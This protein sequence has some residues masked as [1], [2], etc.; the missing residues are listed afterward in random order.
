MLVGMVKWFSPEKGFGFILLDDGTEVFVHY[1]SIVGDGFRILHAEEIVE[2]EI[3]DTIHGKQA[4]NVR[5]VNN[6]I[7]NKDESASNPDNRARSAG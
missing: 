4:K 6:T 3:A 7:N 1:T 5:R 2:F